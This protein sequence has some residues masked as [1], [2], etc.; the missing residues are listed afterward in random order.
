MY[1]DTTSEQ[2]ASACAVR[3]SPAVHAV[4]EP[5]TLRTAVA[6]ASACIVHGSTM[7]TTFGRVCGGVGG[8]VGPWVAMSGDTGVAGGLFEPGRS[9]VESCR[10]FGGWEGRVGAVD[11]TVSLAGC[12]RSDECRCS[13]GGYSSLAVDRPFTAQ[14][15]CSNRG[16]FDSLRL[17]DG[18]RVF[19]KVF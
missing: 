2:F 15:A 18:R 8:V 1:T 14:G 3:P 11:R 17:S 9:V 10:Q 4:Y 16:V 12:R 13:P 5:L 6:R 7:I 19:G